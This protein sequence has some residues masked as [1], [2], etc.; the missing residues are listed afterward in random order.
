MSDT[1]QNAQVTQRDAFKN[2]QKGLTNTE[3]R[4]VNSFFQPVMNLINRG[5]FDK[6]REN[7]SRRMEQ[8][9]KK[10]NLGINSKME[11]ALKN[12]FRVMTQ[13][14]SSKEKREALKKDVAK[15]TKRKSLMRRAARF[16]GR[17]GGGSMKMPQEY[18][19]TSLFRKN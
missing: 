18:A 19:K 15:S 9:D 17:G 10:A 3:I 12:M 13:G 14:P 5:E 8:G 2:A 1:Q 4:K 7:F 16:G 11:T 6:A